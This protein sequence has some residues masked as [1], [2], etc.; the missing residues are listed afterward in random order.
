MMKKV[1]YSGN[2]RSAHRLAMLVPGENTFPVEL[3][4][5]L[6]ELKVVSEVKS[7]QKSY[8]DKSIISKNTEN[9][10]FDKKE[11]TKHNRGDR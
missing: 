11:K 1:W 9:K 4:N 6:I 8:E 7:I 10:S 5:K 2:R 3:A